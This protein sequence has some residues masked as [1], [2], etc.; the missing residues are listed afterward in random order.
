MGGTGKDNDRAV[1]DLF[2]DNFRETLFRSFF[3]AL[4][5]VCD[6]GF[7]GEKRGGGSCR[8]PDGEGGDGEDHKLRLPD[9]GKVGGQNNFRAYRYAGEKPLMLPVAADLGD[10]LREFS[11]EGH[12]LS[13]AAAHNG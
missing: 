11:P 6:N 9:I 8:L 4:A 3:Q 7:R 1:G 2:G 10:L 12:V 5:D 13:G